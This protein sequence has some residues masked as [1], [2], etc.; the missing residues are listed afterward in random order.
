M[1]ITKHALWLLQ[2]SK[3]WLH[4]NVQIHAKLAKNK[5]HTCKTCNKCLSSKDGLIRH[6]RIHSGEKP[7]A[8]QDCNK[9]FSDPSAF[10]N[11]ERVHSGVKPF[12]CK[13]CEKNFLT[14]ANLIRHERIHS[15]EKPYDCQVCNN[16]FTPAVAWEGAWKAT[17][18]INN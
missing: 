6:E 7:Y 9:C 18:S 17:I 16:F 15:G 3:V 1:P 14:K 12:S 8:C 13:L 4:I 10:S 5:Q 2:P 11:H